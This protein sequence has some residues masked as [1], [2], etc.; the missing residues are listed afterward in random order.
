M[1][2]L[3]A[4]LSNITDPGLHRKLWDWFVS[5]RTR[6]PFSTLLPGLT[7]DSLAVKLAG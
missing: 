5:T 7:W 6:R 2:S 4:G 3:P 1:N